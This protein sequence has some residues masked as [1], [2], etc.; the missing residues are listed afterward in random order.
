V[1]RSRYAIYRAVRRLL[2]PPGP[3]LTRSALRLSLA[4]REEISRG[5]ARGES[6]RGI[7]RRLGRSP[8]TVSRRSPATAGA[9]AIGPA[10]PIVQRCG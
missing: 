4:E 5:L 6:L 1:P 9:A 3:E 10:R 8:S 2:R 7:A